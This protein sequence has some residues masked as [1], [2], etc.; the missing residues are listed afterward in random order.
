LRAGRQAGVDD[1]D[2]TAGVAGVL[3]GEKRDGGSD[4]L[5]G[6][7]AFD[8]RVSPYREFT[9]GG[10]LLSYGTDFTNMFRLVGAYTAKVRA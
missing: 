7:G 5:C 1:G 2:R 3:G 9:L 6:G 4:L 8:A 10:G